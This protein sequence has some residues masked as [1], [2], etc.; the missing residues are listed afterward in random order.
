MKLAQ[1]TTI[2]ARGF[3]RWISNR[4]IW[5]P[6]FPCHFIFI[7]HQD[8]T[9]ARSHQPAPAARWFPERGMWPIGSANIADAPALP[10]GHHGQNR[11]SPV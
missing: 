10:G 3:G 6:Y 5:L 1:A 7:P 9:L 4:T 8:E 11:Y 2:G